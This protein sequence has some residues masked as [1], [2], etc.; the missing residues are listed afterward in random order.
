MSNEVTVAPSLSN[1]TVDQGNSLNDQMQVELQNSITQCQVWAH[2]AL[3]GQ[4]KARLEH[5]IRNKIE[6]T[7]E[8]SMIQKVEDALNQFESSIASK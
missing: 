5:R 6:S 7:L 3:R 8:A 1:F 4:P 2:S